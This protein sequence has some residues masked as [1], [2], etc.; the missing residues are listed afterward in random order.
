[1]SN[2][3]VYQAWVC[4]RVG[5]L[6]KL[7]PSQIISDL[8]KAIHM[9]KEWPIEPKE[10]IEI[11]SKPEFPESK[12]NKIKAI[13]LNYSADMLVSVVNLGEEEVDIRL[14]TYCYYTSF[15]EDA[16]SAKMNYKRKILHH[17]VTNYLNRKSLG[18]EDKDIKR[19]RKNWEEV[20]LKN[21]CR[22][23]GPELSRWEIKI[24]KKI[25][26]DFDQFFT[27]ESEPI[28]AESEINEDELQKTGN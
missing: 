25:A 27:T 6:H 1:M 11:I 26:C 10:L 21:F 4:D 16:T 12:A 22:F 14:V 13:V 18:I 24:R 17:I 7:T 19:W 2:R 15:G 5:K 9:Q 28:I 23:F 3:M 8:Q 20:S